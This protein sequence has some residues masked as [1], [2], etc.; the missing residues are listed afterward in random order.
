M[1]GDIQHQYLHN[2]IYNES[3]TCEATQ[4]NQNIIIR[5]QTKII[6]ELAKLKSMLNIL[7]DTRNPISNNED[8]TENSKDVGQRRP[9]DLPVDSYE[10]LETFEL[11]L[12]K[13]DVLQKLVKLNIQVWNMHIFFGFSR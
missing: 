2:K 6:G 12:S 3:H 4:E 8:S 11:E 10:K 1:G 9:Y 5:N 13:P 7:L